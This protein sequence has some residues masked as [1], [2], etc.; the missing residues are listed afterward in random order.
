MKKIFL[1]VSAFLL[2]GLSA[3]AFVVET[4]YIQNNS[5]QYA[6]AV[7]VSCN[8]QTAPMCQDLCGNASSCQREEPFCRNCAGT[9]SPLLR[10]LFTEISRLYE[11][12]GQLISPEPFVQFMKSQ[13]YVLLDSKSVF[14]FYTPVGGEAF[15]KELVTICQGNSEE[16]LLAVRLDTVNV[17]VELSYVLCREPGQSTRVHE[18]QLR[19]PDF[20][21][22]PLKTPL[23][24]NLN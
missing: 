15:V 7:Q 14:N 3:S 22:R 9:T 12:K 23:I 17:P 5:G 10:Q 1:Y 13:K 11:I 24:F 2:M 16:T 20:G 4:G 6:K 8:A 19:R 21:A 18:V